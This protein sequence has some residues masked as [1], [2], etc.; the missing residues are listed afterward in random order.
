[1]PPENVQSSFLEQIK[2]KLPINTSLADEIAETLNISRDSAYRRIRGETVLSLD[3]AKT[4]CNKFEVSLDALTGLESGIIPF[5]HLVV[6]NKPETFE[7]WLKLMLENLE[8]INRYSGNKEIVFTAKDVPVFHYFRY[9]ELCAFKM[10][11]WMK[12]VLSYPEFQTRKF[13]SNSVRSDLLSLA[14]KISKTYHEVPSVELWSE[15]TTN[16][17]LKQLEFYHES[18]FFNSTAD[19][20]PVFDEY[21][22]MVSDI[23]DFAARGYKQEGASFTLYKNEILIADNTVLYRMDDRKTVYI[24]HNITEL[25]LTTHESFT[26]QTES[27]INNLQARSV[28]ISTTGEKERNKFF[29]RMDEKIDAVKKRVG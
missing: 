4:L 19:S 6:N 14:R 9:P 17:T 16:V 29:N 5:R 8:L 12:S 18:G 25:L 20:N 27:F 3:E 23:K 10:F 26:L 15:E 13:S 1:M 24:S 28:L 11:F 21:K 2:K 7:Q 22:Q